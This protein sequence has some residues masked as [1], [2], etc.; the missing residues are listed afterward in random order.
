MGSDYLNFYF[1]LFFFSN[2]SYSVVQNTYIFFFNREE[3]CISER[4]CLVRDDG[5][6]PT[7]EVVSRKK[8]VFYFL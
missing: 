6:V 2:K 1:L 3:I 7:L 8:N 5:G 4:F